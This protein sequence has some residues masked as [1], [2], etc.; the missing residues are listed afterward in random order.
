MESI[1]AILPL[2]GQRYIDSFFDVHFP[3]YLS[4]GNLDGTWF[5]KMDLVFVTTSD[6]VAKIW[7][8]LETSKL[9]IPANL[10][11]HV[12]YIAKS[13]KEDQVYD[14]LSMAFRHGIHKYS[15]LSQNFLFLNS[16]LM[17]SEGSLKNGAHYLNQGFLAVETIAPRV[18]GSAMQKDAFAFLQPDNSIS[19]PSRNLVELSFKN[20]LDRTSYHCWPGYLLF[21]ISPRFRIMHSFAHSGFFIKFEDGPRDFEGPNDRDFIYS[22]IKDRSRIKKLTDSDDF[23]YVD[24]CELGNRKHISNSKYLSPLA[25]RKWHYS[26]WPRPSH[27]E[28][29][30]IPILHK[31]AQITD[32][33]IE[34]GKEFASEK[35]LPILKE[36][37]QPALHRELMLDV[38][39]LKNLFS[40]IGQRL[41]NIERL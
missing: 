32:D 31:A 29:F 16:D 15:S 30:K 22:A 7:S 6:D 1:V 13:I 34:R 14:S 41:R 5:Q 24:F 18:L 10:K 4:K 33:E 38:T 12:S 9:P 8:R 2:W 35:I 36:L 20:E 3:N 23:F 40:G 25:F 19:I 26:G 21:D 11:C 39:V 27:I 37:Q 28:N 17:F